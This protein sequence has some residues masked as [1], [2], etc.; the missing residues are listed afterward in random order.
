MSN[1]SSS[2]TFRDPNTFDVLG[3][4]SVTSDGEPVENLNEL[5]CVGGQVYANVLS[6]DSVL[7]IDP[8]NGA[9]TATIDA[10]SLRTGEMGDG[11][12]NGIVYDPTAETFLLTGKNWPTLFEVRLAKGPR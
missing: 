7:R 9:V 4:V 1:G 2:L 12:L 5:E 8:V 3:T 6:S 11:V 10:S